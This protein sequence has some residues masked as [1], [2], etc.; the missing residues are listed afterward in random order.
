MNLWK[1]RIK[2][3]YLVNIILFLLTIVTTTIVGA[4]FYVDQKATSWFWFFLNGWKF[5]LPLMTILLVHEMGHFLAGRHYK[6]DVTLPYFIPA[7]PPLGTF[8]AFIKIRSPIP[9][10]P[11]L[12][13]I[14]A[15]GPLFGSV[16]AIPL[17]LVGLRYSQV[18]EKTSEIQ[19]LTFG[20]SLLMEI[21]CY[22][23]LGHFTKDA[24]I[25]L[26]PT[27]MA[28]WFGLFVT[29]MN[30]L[31]MGQLDGGHVIYALFG[32]RTAKII[33]TIVFACLIFMGFAFWNG[34][35]IFG[36]LILFLGLNHPAPMDR[37]TDLDSTGKIIGIAAVI[38]FF[39]TFTPIPI[40]PIE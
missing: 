1:E 32:P 20:S 7:I 2:S 17:L 23:G 36:M 29:S 39:I 25:I 30:L 22:I 15:F 12:I 35:L 8:G 33:S 6:L 5:S 21:L 4:L 26:H 13:R 10:L 37:Y 38:L 3:S 14:G 31:P 19:G 27:A 9:N 28:A 16:A 40:S 18:L 11:A 34:W 24:T